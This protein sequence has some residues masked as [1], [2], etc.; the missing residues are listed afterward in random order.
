MIRI[1]PIYRLFAFLLLTVLAAGILTAEVPPELERAENLY[2]Q[3]EAQAARAILKDWLDANNQSAEFSTVVRSY[4]GYFEDSQALLAELDRFIDQESRQDPP[5]IRWAAET[6]ELMGDYSRAKAYF[7]KGAEVSTHAETALSLNMSSLEIGLLLGELEETEERIRE[8]LPECTSPAQ[9][10]RGLLI[11]SRA[12]HLREG[13]VKSWK[14]ARGAVNSEA[15]P[16]ALFWITNLAAVLEKAEGSAFLEQLREDHP[17]S[18]Q[19]QMAEGTVLRKTDPLS[20]G[21]SAVWGDDEERQQSSPEESSHSAVPLSAHEAETPPP[22]SET[23]QFNGAIQTGSF[24]D[25]ENA[26]ELMKVLE[27]A[28]Y[29]TEIRPS[30]GEGKL[31]HRVVVINLP[32]DG[33]EGEL[34]KLRQKGF[35]GFIL[36]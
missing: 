23:G 7:T 22:A 14:A 12:L 6:A 5:F 18:P 3:G 4:L 16:Q 32:P 10:S 29:E 33:V 27:D 20:L 8:L 31:Y 28:G 25:E 15:S 34:E 36:R 1:P 9:R 30:D 24:L 13:D 19:Y 35:D 2:H 26:R 17:L 11:L 21:F